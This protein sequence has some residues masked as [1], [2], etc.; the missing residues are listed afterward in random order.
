MIEIN[1]RYHAVVFGW[2]YDVITEEFVDGLI[3]AK[4]LDP[5]RLVWRGRV[6]GMR[7]ILMAE[8]N[9]QASRHFDRG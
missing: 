3:E 8:R 6:I 7:R 5:K 4:H 2:R 9:D 1:R